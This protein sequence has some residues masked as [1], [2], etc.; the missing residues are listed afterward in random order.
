M[1]DAT[2]AVAGKTKSG[3]NPPAPSFHK[4]SPAF[5]VSALKK[6]IQGKLSMV[7]IVGDIDGLS[8]GI[9]LIGSEKIA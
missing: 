3:N 2:L 8:Y 9:L 5:H 1:F 7:H 4:A 6:A